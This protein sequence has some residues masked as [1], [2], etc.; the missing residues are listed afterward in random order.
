MV[1]WNCKAKTVKRVIAGVGPLAGRLVMS[2]FAQA[3]AMALCNLF[4]LNEGARSGQA[5]TRF[6]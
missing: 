1:L 5:Q 6:V 4:Y 3:F 2:Y